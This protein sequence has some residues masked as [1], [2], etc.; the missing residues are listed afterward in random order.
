MDGIRRF[1]CSAFIETETYAQSRNLLGHLTDEE[2]DDRLS[3]LLWAL[4]RDPELVAARVGQRNLWVAVTDYPRL[5]I[6]FR[7]R[8]DV[9]DECE[10]LWI[11]EA[12]I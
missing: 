4:G 7:P 9:E 11:E 2:I 3:A 10:L 12:D 5:R 1:V 8:G 6:Y